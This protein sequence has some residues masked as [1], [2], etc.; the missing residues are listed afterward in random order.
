MNEFKYHVYYEYLGPSA[1]DPFAAKPL[2]S[3]QVRHYLDGLSAILPNHYSSIVKDDSLYIT[4]VTSEAEDETDAAIERC[5]VKLNH[6]TPGLSLL[7][8]RLS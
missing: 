1:G 8:K 7:I 5:V 3:E 2:S 6:A 4:V